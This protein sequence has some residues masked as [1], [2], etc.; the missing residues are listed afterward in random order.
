MAQGAVQVAVAA[1][2]DGQGNAGDIFVTFCYLYT[3]LTWVQTYAGPTCQRQNIIRISRDNV[4]ESGCMAKTAGQH[5]GGRLGAH[6]REEQV[7][8]GLGSADTALGQEALLT[9]PV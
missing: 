7:G 1:L 9:S 2:V 3:G 8:G 4:T 6:W 5:R